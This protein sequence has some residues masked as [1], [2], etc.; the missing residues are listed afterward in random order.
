MSMTI[1]ISMSTK[2]VSTLIIHILIDWKEIPPD[3]F[4][5]EDIAKGVSIGGTIVEP[6]SVHAFNEIT[7][8]VTYFSGIL[9]KEIGPAIEKINEWLG[10]YM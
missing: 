9:A 3:V 1:M 8:L 6:R 5:N 4:R 2:L 7:F 10:Y